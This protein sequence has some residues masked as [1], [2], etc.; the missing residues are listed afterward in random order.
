M[1]FFFNG[2]LWVSP[3]TMSVVDDSALNN[4]NPNVGNVTA[5]LGPSTG[6]VPNTAISLGTP[7][8]A[9]ATL[10]SG[11]LLDS[12]LRAFSPSDET[13]G[14]AEI[15]AIRVNPALQS[16][17]TLLD[18]SANP[19]IV[20]NSADYGLYTNQ[21]KV[22]VSVGTT[23]GKKII[24]ALGLNYYTMDNITQN[25]FTVQYVG[26]SASAV[27]SITPT[28]V[29]LSNPTGTV[30]A[31]IPLATYPTIQQ[32]VDKINS[33]AGYSASVVGGQGANAA[34]NGLDGVTAQDVRTAPYTAT[35]NLQACIAALNTA[36]GGL[37]VATAAANA[38]QPPASIAYTYLTG[39]T[40]GV[41][42]NTN[43]SN[44]FTVLQQSDVQWVSPASGDP[45]IHAMTDAHVQY[46]S[47]VGRMERRSIVGMPLGSTDAAAIAEALTLNSDRTSL[48]H[49]GMYDYN[50]A[51]QNILYAPY[52]T[53]GLLAGMFSAVSPGT[54]LTNKTITVRGLER[55]LRNPLDTDPLLEAGVLPIEKTSQGFKVVQSISTWLANDNYNRVEQSCGAALD[56]AVRAVRQ[57]LDVLR[58]QGGNPFILGQAVSITKATLTLLSV[59]QP[60]GPG[61][62]VGDAA[63]PSFKNITAQLTGN[64]LAVSFQCSPVI[65]VNYIPVTVYAVPYSG[66]ATA[67]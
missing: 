10:L 17:L 45:S 7:Q 48:V 29:T 36:A 37:F 23:V 60:Q 63:S 67:A 65:P 32:L 58:G 43:W 2:R 30:V 46:M 41:T 15:I 49:L 42:T 20:L 66:T 59:A 44:A 26:S 8:Q 50:A 35:A 38:S 47:T 39:G 28:Q 13:G 51:G 34:L 5:I 27:M 14:P 16:T 24:A 62:L 11:D 9:T 21:I 52:I 55:I 6:G 12:V 3:A 33:I 22:S 56:Y 31:T 1:A 19:S 64:V 4:Q 54:A 18:S 40:D 57:A 25:A 61:V 53:A